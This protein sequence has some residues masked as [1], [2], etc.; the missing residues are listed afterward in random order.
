MDNIKLKENYTDFRNEKINKSKLQIY[1]SCIYGKMKEGAKFYDIKNNVGSKILD[2]RLHK[3][4]CQLKPKIC[5]LGIQF[6]YIYKKEGSEKMMI[7]LQAVSKD[8]FIE[9]ELILKKGEYINNIKLWVKEKLI[10]FQVF[11]NLK[12]TK[13]FGYGG[14]DCL[15][16]VPDLKHYDKSV[17]GFGIYGEYQDGIYSMFF[18]YLDKKK[19]SGTISIGIFYL[20]YKLKKIRFRKKIEQKLKKLNDNLKVL[21]QVCLLPD[22]QFFSIIK[23]MIC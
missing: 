18:Y 23:Y 9:Q 1:S 7:N 10:G 2:Y 6:I 15:V 13:K 11:T 3:I 20:R 17:V 21:Y 14:D 12:N 22:Y 19:Y 8:D 4:R 16:N 5:I